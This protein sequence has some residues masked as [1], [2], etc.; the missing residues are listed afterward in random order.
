M[1][2]KN[3]RSFRKNPLGGFNRQDVVAYLQATAK[4]HREETDALR[5]E[6]DKLRAE[7]LELRHKLDELQAERANTAAAE[8]LAEEKDGLL[9]QKDRQL[10]ESSSALADKEQEAFRLSREL[11]RLH[12]EFSAL[13]DELGGAGE[14]LTS[15]RGRLV[16]SEERNAA[17]ESRALDQER[18]LSESAGA[19]AALVTTRIEL[20]DARGEIGA[21]TGTVEELNEKIARYER[22]MAMYNNI[23]FGMGEIEGAAPLAMAELER[24][25]ISLQ[26]ASALFAGLNERFLSLMEVHGR[27]QTPPQV[28]E[29]QPESLEETRMEI[30]ESPAEQLPQDESP[31]LFTEQGSPM[32]RDFVPK[33]FE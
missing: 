5:S 7:C 33:E 11:E 13:K 24:S 18:R 28:P 4:E 17:L 29:E 8:R 12:A 32:I 15:L 22:E 14:T 30:L 10:L 31:A 2:A 23:I 3:D 21:L 9:A 19:G 25:R 6:A 20:D 1:V 16:E 26:N 27:S